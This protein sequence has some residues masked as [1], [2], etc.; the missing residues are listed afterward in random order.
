M[1][2]PGFLKPGCDTD[3]PA[4][5]SGI[6]SIAPGRGPSGPWPRTV[7]ACIESIV[8]GSQRSDWRPDQ[9]PTGFSPL[10]LNYCLGSIK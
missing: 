2:A 5:Q 8:T 7:R 6:P 10:V 4:R 1:F 3:R 9:R